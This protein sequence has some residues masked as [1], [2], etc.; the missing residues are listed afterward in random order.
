MD[1]SEEKIREL[2]KALLRATDEEE[3]RTRGE[4]LRAAIRDHLKGVH[5]QLKTMAA[6]TRSR[7]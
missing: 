2:S 4:E 1:P 3:V 6:S 5:D 7:R